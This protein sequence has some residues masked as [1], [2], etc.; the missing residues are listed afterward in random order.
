M[1]AIGTSGGSASSCGR[2]GP[3][4]PPPPVPP[5]PPPPPAPAPLA[6]SLP[7]GRGASIFLPAPT[8]C[9]C[10]HRH[11]PYQ[12]WSLPPRPKSPAA[13]AAQRTSRRR[14]AR[15]VYPFPRR[16]LSSRLLFTAAMNEEYDVIVL[17][18]GLTECI[19]SGI[20]SVNGKK[21]LHMDRN[22]YYGGESASITPLEDLYKRFNL[23]GSPPESMGR[24]RDWNVDLIPKFLMANG[25][26]VKM[27]LYT[28]V[29]RYLDFKV[30]EGSFVYKGGKIYKVP[31]TE[32]EALASSLMGLFE[33]RRF[34]KFLVYVANFDENDA[35]TFEGVD[36]KK[37]TMRDVYKKFDL[38]QD[39][40]DFT[41]HALALYRTDDYLDQPCQET[42]NRIKLYSESLARYGKSPYLY[43]LYGLGE[44]PQGFA[45]LSAIYGGTYMLNKPIQ[46]I[47]VEDGK[48][49]GVKSEG[50]VARCKQL[51]CDPSY[52][53]ERV[54]KVGK[55]IRV[56]CILSHPI[57]NT[58]DANSCQIIIP[59]NQ[60]NRKSDI[61]VCMISS[62]H[63]VAAQGK[64]IAIVSTTVET[65]D[66]EREIKP[67]L[68]LLE[69]IEQKFVSV[70]D[71]F[72]PTDL[73]RESQIFISRTYDATTHF[74]T[75][76]D[77]IKDIYKR[78]MGSEF[79]FEEMKRKKNDIYG[80]EEQQ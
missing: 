16:R 33:K 65:N 35:R 47:V 11:P 68:E 6:R 10:G 9:C 34:R 60:V 66:P 24:G 72:A 27:L 45:R 43:P 70:C 73:G 56:I 18:T 2:T 23:P 15:D 71:L 37:N 59:Q 67:A 69:P 42:I 79:D 14:D 64:Y 50:E 38:G 49:V 58:N 48:V 17:G 61:Y 36:P 29:T 4:Q 46:E 39:V 7:G 19:L 55:V 28:E 13:S 40:I 51:I 25:Q 74:E 52:V 30:I 26:L 31:S 62:A 54:K 41:G 57:K 20:M 5:P 77:D 32:A 21:V 80:E 78:M 3:A 1:E 8:S 76:C 44:L 53:P 12:Q 63:N 75:T 22:A